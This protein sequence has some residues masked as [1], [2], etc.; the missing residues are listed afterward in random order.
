MKKLCWM[1][2]TLWLLATLNLAPAQEQK[3]EPETMQKPKFSPE[4]AKLN[5]LAGK[6][7]VDLMTH[8]NPMGEGGP[9]K[10]QIHNHWGLDSMFLIMEHEDNGPMG[11]YK[12]HGV[13][14]Y[15]MMEKRY[16]LWWY[17]NWGEI[18]N[19]E[20]NFVGD[21]LVLVNEMAM[22]DG[23]PFKLKLMWYKEGKKVK[24]RI[25]SDTGQGFSA[26]LDCTYSPM[27]A[28]KK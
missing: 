18:S 6:F 21:T 17:T 26:L 9:G 10:G 1:L 13:L 24:F 19:Y 27:K 4:L 12:G 7:D 22:P 23:T 8:K 16:E 2:T 5:L 25:L 11:N 20:G 3:P 28:G 15:D 14:G